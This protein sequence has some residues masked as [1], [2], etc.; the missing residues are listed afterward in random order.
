MKPRRVMIIEDSPTMRVLLEAIIAEDSRLETVGSYET[1]EDALANV[2]KDQ[3]DVISMDVLLPGMDG[4]TATGE[5]LSRYP[6]P[7]VIVSSTASSRDVGVAMAGL[8]QGAVAVL[9][10][11]GAPDEPCFEREAR[12]LRDQLYH[13]SQVRVACRPPRQIAAVAPIARQLPL[14]ERGPRIRLSEQSGRCRLIAIGASTGGPPVLEQL[15]NQLVPDFPFPILI[16]QHIAPGFAEGLVQWLNSVTPHSVQLA[17]N[18][19]HMQPGKV[20][21]APDG[22]HLRVRGER[23]ILEDAVPGSIHCPS[24]DVLFES[25]ALEHGDAAVGLLM[26][27]MGADGAKGLLALKNAGS[28]TAT[29]TEVSCVVYGMP[30]AADRLGAACAQLDPK[31]MAGHLNGMKKNG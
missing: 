14:R 18:W 5:F 8:K 19:Q 20:Y 7:I 4:L 15:L 13:M 28:W 11:P 29:Q 30:Q 3:P 24:I 6:I 2:A 27:G 31:E 1:A 10:K 22:K 9:G 25:V 17:E 12:W 16:V 23:L 21:L 26:T